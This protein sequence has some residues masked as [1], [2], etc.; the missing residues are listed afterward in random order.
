MDIIKTNDGSTIDVLSQ[1]N[2]TG[3]G[4]DHVIISIYNTTC[5]DSSHIC[6]EFEE[7]KK[8]IEILKEHTIDCE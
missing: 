2:Y 7:I 6:L 4:L 3:E 5:K 8:L 1:D